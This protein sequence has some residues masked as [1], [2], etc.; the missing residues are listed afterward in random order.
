VEDNPL[1]LMRGDALFS[2][3]YGMFPLEEGTQDDHPLSWGSPSDDIFAQRGAKLS[4][5]LF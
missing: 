1:L 2:G 4:E 3:L 5:R